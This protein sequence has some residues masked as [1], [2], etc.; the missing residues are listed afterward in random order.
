MDKYST[1]ENV[2]RYLKELPK[3]ISKEIILAV[4]EIV[5]GCD[6]GISEDIKWGSICFK[7]TE[8]FC[9]FKVGKAAISLVVFNGAKLTDSSKLFNTKSS[10]EKTR[11][12]KWNSL[13][14][15]DSK[16][17]NKLLKES[18]NTPVK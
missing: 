15:I 12:I 17:L 5:L 13:E 6:K 1:N 3:G 2:E 18:A 4:R 16:S 7:K 11:T 9:G 10:G 14:E 8:N